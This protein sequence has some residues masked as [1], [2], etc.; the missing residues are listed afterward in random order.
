MYWR[1]RWPARCCRCSWFEVILQKWPINK[2]YQPQIFSPNNWSKNSWTSIWTY[3]LVLCSWSNRRQGGKHFLCAICWESTE[4]LHNRIYRNIKLD[5][6]NSS[7][8]NF[9]RARLI[10]HGGVQENPLKHVRWNIHLLK[11]KK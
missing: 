10:I 6:N 2:V 4:L 8:L 11:K 3:E 5:R 9:H 1:N 7:H